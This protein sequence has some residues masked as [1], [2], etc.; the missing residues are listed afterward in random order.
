MQMVDVPATMT[1]PLRVI[2]AL[3]DGLLIVVADVEYF[4]ATPAVPVVLVVGLCVAARLVDF[5]PARSIAGP[6]I[7]VLVQLLFGKAQ[8]V[9]EIVGLGAGQRVERVRV[10][11]AG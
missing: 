1:R 10:G 5:R 11:T 3:V 6:R 9:D 8:L 4:T 2:I 7:A